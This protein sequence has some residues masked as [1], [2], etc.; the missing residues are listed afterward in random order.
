MRRGTARK[1]EKDKM[2]AAG[3]VFTEKEVEEIL[4]GLGYQK[5]TDEFDAARRNHFPPAVGYDSGGY[6]EVSACPPAS[7][8][9]SGC[10]SL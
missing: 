1:E 5:G 9:E 2:Y 4:I 6:V 3:Q 8:V 10:V 7:R